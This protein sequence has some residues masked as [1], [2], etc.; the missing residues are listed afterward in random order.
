VTGCTAPGV[1]CPDQGTNFVYL[2]TAPRRLA[3]LVKDVGLHPHGAFST[4][5]VAD[6]GARAD[7]GQKFVVADTHNNWIAIW[8]LGAPGWIYIPPGH[9]PLVHSVGVTVGADQRDPVPVYGRA[10]PESAAYAAYPGVPVQA[11]VPLQYSILAGQ[12]YALQDATVSTDYYR[13][14]TF[15]GTPPTDHVDI[16]GQ[17]AYY[18][19]SLGHRTAYVRA[20][21][22]DIVPAG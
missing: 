12:R 1:R 7:A 5:D 8:Y 2:R 16:R 6:V 20:A 10:Y 11:V 22:V 19:V 13:A 21:D 9:T 15:A 14:T 17:D 3:R 18:Q 4:T